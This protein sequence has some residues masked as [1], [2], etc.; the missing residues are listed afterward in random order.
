MIW[1]LGLGLGVC[2]QWAIRYLPSINY[3][4]ALRAHSGIKPNIKIK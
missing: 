4:R 3:A 1:G 2:L